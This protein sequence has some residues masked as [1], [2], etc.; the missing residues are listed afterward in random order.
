MGKQLDDRVHP[1]ADP[2]GEVRLEAVMADA[3]ASDANAE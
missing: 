1:V 2:I 3:E